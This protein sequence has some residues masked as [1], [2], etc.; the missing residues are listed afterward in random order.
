[1]EEFKTPSSPSER[2]LT[3]NDYLPSAGLVGG[4]FAVVIFAIS[5]IFGYM[6]INAEPSGSP[7][8]LSSIS[9]IFVCLIGAFSGLVGVWHFSKEV[10]PRFKMGQGAAIGFL[11]GAV[12]AVVSVLLTNIWQFIDPEYTQKLLESMIANFEMM[13]IPDEMLDTMIESTEESINPGLMRQLF[14]SIPIQ[15]VLSTLTALI[16]TKMFAQKEDEVTF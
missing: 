14:L 12:V 2:K 10:T 16:G 13:E 8:G 9:G 1:M 6:Q 3:F 15:G 7:F 11:T 5:I 4:I